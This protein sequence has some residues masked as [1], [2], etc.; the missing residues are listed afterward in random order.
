[1]WTIIKFDKKNLE[2]LKKDLKDKLGDEIS[3]YSPKLLVQKYKNNKLINKEFNLLGNYIFCFH[4]KF[5]RSSIIDQLK[6]I[7]GLKYFLIGFVRTQKEITEFIKKCQESENKDGYL[8][9]NFLELNLSSEYKFSSG[10]FTDMIFKVIDLQKKKISILI[11]NIK[12]TI[13]KKDFLYSPI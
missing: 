5:E 8:S 6:F 13:N 3:F 4:K 7:K 12:T 10:P 2:N 11:G 9:E 1:M